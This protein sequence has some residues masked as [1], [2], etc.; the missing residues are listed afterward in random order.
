[1]L[2]KT[3]KE[4]AM[5]V[6]IHGWSD[7][8]KS[9]ID[10][11]K[12]LSKPAPEGIGADVKHI[13]LGDYI[14]LDDQITFDDLIEALQKAWVQK[15]QLP[16]QP[17]SVDVIVHS[18]GGLVVRHWL[19]R[20]FKPHN[21]PIHRLLMLAP[22]NFGSPLAHSGRSV[23]GR[24]IKGWKGERLFETGT[25]ILR[26]LEL[27]SPYTSHLAFQD[28]FTDIPYYSQDAILCT[29]LIG[30]AGYSGISSIANRPGTDGTVRVSTA[31]L[32]AKSLL[33]DFTDSNDDVVPKGLIESA[34]VAFGILD[35]EDHSSITFKGRGN[36][37]QHSWDII[38]RALTVE[39]HQYADW[40]NDLSVSTQAIV[41]AAEKRRGN[42]YDQYANLVVKLEDNLQ[43]SVED[44]VLE[45]YVN[46][47]KGTRNRKLTQ[48]VNEDVIKSVHTNKENAAYRSFLINV[49]VLQSLFQFPE[50]CL[51]MSVCARPEYSRGNVGYKTYGDKDIGAW[52]IARDALL[53]F[54][55][56]N[57]TLMVKMIIQR[58][59]KEDVFRFRKLN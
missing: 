20:F 7:N 9:F 36:K 53:T 52:S 19:T 30:N 29:V 16:T 4:F 44:Y 2:G 59:Q 42:H 18:T 49:T 5:L 51:N 1:V 50:D 34:P 13:Y 37:K 8:Y 41:S 57:K 35:Q 22:A 45:F 55:E 26:G 56:P 46:D 10:M 31:N 25:E 14:S 38:C 48:R 23:I 17:R 15:E 28:L 54:F 24:V 33:L 3:K 27:A 39:S 58:Y 32:N 21:A 11:G 40:R 6:I 43:H 12:A 47:D